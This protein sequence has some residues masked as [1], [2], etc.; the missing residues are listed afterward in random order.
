MQYSMTFMEK[1]YDCLAAHL[2]KDRDVEA[3]AYLLCRIS[4]T[5]EEIRLLVREVI[6][7]HEVDIEEASRVHMKI[8]SRSFMRTMKRADKTRQVFVFV[9][10]HP[11]TFRQHSAKDDREELMLF[12]TAYTRIQTAGVHA[13]IVFSDPGMPDGRAW[14]SDGTT[15]PLTVI[16]SIGERFKFYFPANE[17]ETVPE[18]FDRQ[19]RAF[20]EDNQRLLGK[21]HIG[22]VGAGGTGSA[23]I[24]EL[25]RLGVGSLTVID[26]QLFER[27]NVNRVY[28][29]R[30]SDA[31]AEKVGI[32]RRSV[33]EIGLGTQLT[34]I[35]RP[36]S[37]E[38]A[39]AALRNA[40]IVFG[41]TDDQWGRSILCRMAVYY[42]IPVIDMGVKIISE[43]GAIQSVQGRVTTLLAGYACL[44]CRERIT[45]KGVRE[46]SLAETDPEQ[47]RQLVRDG[48]ADELATPSP[49]V[50]PFTTGIATIAISELLHRLTGFLGADRRSN[51][52]IVFFDEYRTRTNRRESQEDCICGDVR[53]IMRGDVVP[54]LDITWRPE[55]PNN[56]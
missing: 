32:V 27:S 18:F 35:N 42:N 20:G 14:L 26:G 1:D 15:R 5:A 41:C 30:V 29:S 11:P 53:Y 44:Y 19:V 25:I 43:N 12:R 17:Q 51:E 33:G 4:S 39:A 21:L 8:R 36:I 34:T 37:F 10:S 50:I 7:V 38:S 52:V 49:S 48:Y 23:I 31:G 46:Q 54:L 16:R 40:D 24:E 13:S 2:F 3:A 6:P 28:G 47:F 56:A 22:V 45:P 55:R 9:H